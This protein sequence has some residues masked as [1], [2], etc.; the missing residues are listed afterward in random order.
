MVLIISEVEKLRGA[1]LQQD[2]G[3]NPLCQTDNP[4][5]DLKAAKREAAQAQESLKVNEGDLFTKVVLDGRTRNVSS[6]MKF[7]WRKH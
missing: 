3:N 2:R 7:E 4:S 1:F 5:D 6:L